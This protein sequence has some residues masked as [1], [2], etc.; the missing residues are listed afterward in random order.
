MKA[1]AHD[2]EVE[3]VVGI[4]ELLGVLPAPRI[5]LERVGGIR[6]DVRDRHV[7]EA[8]REQRLAV[9]RAAGDD[10]HRHASLD[11]AVREQLLQRAPVEP[12]SRGRHRGDCTLGRV[13]GISLL[14]L[15]PGISGGSETYARELCRALARVR[16]AAVPRLRAGD[17]AGCVRRPSVVGRRPLPRVENDAGAVAAMSLRRAS[18]R[19]AQARA[20]PRSA[21]RDPLSAQ[22]HAS[23]GRSTARCHDGAGSA[24]RGAP[25]VLRPRRARL[26]QGR[27]RP[28]DSQVANRDHDLR[29]RAPDAA[30]ALP[31]RARSRTHDPPR[32]RPRRL[33]AK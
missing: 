4:L 18:P 7:L 21:R 19:A 20:R 31:A 30:R 33:H 5:R 13:I 25:A 3:R 17:R 6:V 16:H 1:G 9:C 22:R 28:D 27:L 24:A 23:A 29:A 26:P 11:H 15:V 32:R 14:T 2:R 10:E 8:G 12:A